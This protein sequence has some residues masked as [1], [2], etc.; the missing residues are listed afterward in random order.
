MLIRK[1]PED[2]LL[3]FKVQFSKK[4]FDFPSR[5]KLYSKYFVYPVMSQKISQKSINFL[6]YARSLL[7]VCIKTGFLGHRSGLF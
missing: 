3:T 7:R 5:S 4:H 2:L 1:A 6:C